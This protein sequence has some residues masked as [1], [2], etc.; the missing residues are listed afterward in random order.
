MNKVEFTLIFDGV[1]KKMDG[2]EKTLTYHCKEHTLDVL[3]Q[4]ERIAGLEGV[5]DPHSLYLLKTAAMYHD[6]G[7]LEGYSSHEDRSCHIFLQDAGLYHFNERDKS[8]ILGLIDATRLPQKPGNLLEEI[9]C[10]A[11]LDYL[12]RPD[13]F[14]TSDALRREFLHYKVVENNAQW[15]ALQ[16]NFLRKHHYFTKSSVQLRAPVKEQN[17]Q[18]L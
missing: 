3:E 11:D 18:K 4:C 5:T 17:M 9:I 2:L 6:T 7:F 13:F 14:A 1:S 8:I 15:E 16:L 12:G 10:D